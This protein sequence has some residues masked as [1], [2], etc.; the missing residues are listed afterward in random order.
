MDAPFTDLR[1]ESISKATITLR[2]GCR[3]ETCR[4]DVKHKKAFLRVHLRSSV[5]NISFSC[6]SV[7]GWKLALASP[8]NTAY[9]HTVAKFIIM[10]FCGI[11]HA[12]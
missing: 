12:F 6:M 5:D 4:H 8:S 3:L 11:T 9:S 2:D 7:N 10:N 1:M